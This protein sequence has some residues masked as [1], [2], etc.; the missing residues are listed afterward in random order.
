MGDVVVFD[1]KV[2]MYCQWY[3]LKSG[4]QG[5]IL[6]DDESQKNYDR[7]VDFVEHSGKFTLMGSHELPDRTTIFLYRQK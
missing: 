6:R 5:N 3:L 4:Y 7:L 1:P 2:A